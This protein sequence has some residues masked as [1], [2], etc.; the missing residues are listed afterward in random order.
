MINIIKNST[1]GKLVLIVVLGQIL[2]FFLVTK[3]EIAHHYEY[4]QQSY[5]EITPLDRKSVV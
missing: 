5:R 3:P 1:L 4:L 2:Y